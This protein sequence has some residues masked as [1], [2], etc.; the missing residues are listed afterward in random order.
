LSLTAAA[1]D[2]PG[3]SSSS[4][5]S[6]QAVPDV[7]AI[8]LLL[9][10]VLPGVV[11]PHRAVQVDRQALDEELQGFSRCGLAGALVGLKRCLVQGLN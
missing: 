10:G 9:P 7:T 8:V 6:Q 5:T 1:I 4:N 2:G 3:S 11:L